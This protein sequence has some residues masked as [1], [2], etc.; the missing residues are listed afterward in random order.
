MKDHQGGCSAYVTINRNSLSSAT[1]YYADLNPS[2]SNQ[3]NQPGRHMQLHL[4]A[5]ADIGGFLP[6]CTKAVKNNMHATDIALE[7]RWT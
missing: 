4:L 5:R 1:L 3:T 6:Q 7:S 2:N